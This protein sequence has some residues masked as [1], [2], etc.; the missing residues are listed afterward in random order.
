V[1]TNE[2]FQIIKNHWL[3]FFIGII[4]LLMLTDSLTNDKISQN[5]KFIELK[6]QLTS[7]DF[8]DGL[9]GHKHYYFYCD[10]Y[11]NKFQIKAD[12]INYFDKINFPKHKG[13]ELTFKI[14][15]KDFNKKSDCNKI[16]VYEVSTE[17]QTLL[18]LN[19]II[20]FENK[21]YDI[22]IACLF[23]FGATI[24]FTIRYNKYK[25]HIS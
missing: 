10:N 14:T 23:I 19:K 11:C 8:Y 24:G 7:Y 22:I 4:G 2:L 9:R 20:E 3:E 1:K 21:R 15:E 16:F 5:T 13:T 6:S 25:K 17:K 12:Y 18:N